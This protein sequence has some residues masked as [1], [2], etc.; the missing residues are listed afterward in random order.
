M[1]PKTFIPLPAYNEG[2]V[3]AKVVDEVKKEGWKNIIVV[4]DG[5]TDFL[6]FSKE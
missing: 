6:F 5:S 3:I 2:K 1:I 4:D